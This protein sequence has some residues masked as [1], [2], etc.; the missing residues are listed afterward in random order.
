MIFGWANG[1]NYGE[2]FKGG[3]HSSKASQ[4]YATIQNH[5]FKK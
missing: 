5:H 2:W 3:F 1:F 4:V